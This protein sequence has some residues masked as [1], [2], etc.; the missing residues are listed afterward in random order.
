M[1]NSIHGIFEYLEWAAVWSISKPK[2]WVY[3]QKI[4]RTRLAE[5]ELFKKKDLSRTISYQPSANDLV[6]IKDL[7]WA[8][9]NAFDA[10]QMLHK[11]P[12]SR[13]N[14]RFGGFKE[15][16]VSGNSLRGFRCV[17]NEVRGELEGEQELRNSAR[18]I[19]FQL[20][21]VEKEEYTRIL[22]EILAHLGISIIPSS[23]YGYV[24]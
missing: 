5:L 10:L 17:V 19:T 9:V 12:E 20:D 6:T 7:Y 14:E 21:L 3:T 15:R 2:I 11:C 16:L 1:S 18:V 22:V 4:K 8:V 24:S 23:Y 13:L